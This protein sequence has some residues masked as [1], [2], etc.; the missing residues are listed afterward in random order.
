MLVDLSGSLSISPL[1]LRGKSGAYH[2]NRALGWHEACDR[3]SSELI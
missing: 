1:A 3:E 2:G